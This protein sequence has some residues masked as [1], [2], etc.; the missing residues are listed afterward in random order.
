VER[1]LH[2]RW[3]AEARAWARWVRAA[4]GDEAVAALPELAKV[5]RRPAFLHWLALR[6]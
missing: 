5:R 4:P 3:E 1:P 2:E 6:R